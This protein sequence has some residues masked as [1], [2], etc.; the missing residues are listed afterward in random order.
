MGRFNHPIIRSWTRILKTKPK[1]NQLR[2]NQLIIDTMYKVVS[3]GGMS[4]VILIGIV[5]S[6]KM[7]KDIR[8]IKDKE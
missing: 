6:I 7:Y 4:I 5:G 8:N 3:I 2:M 1:I